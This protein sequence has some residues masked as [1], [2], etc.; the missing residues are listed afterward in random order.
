MSGRLKGYVEQPN[1]KPPQAVELIK[2]I[3][4]NEILVE[5]QNGAHAVLYLKTSE[6]RE[7]PKGYLMTKEGRK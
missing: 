1:G 4:S 5:K 6:L 2:K 7:V 3:N